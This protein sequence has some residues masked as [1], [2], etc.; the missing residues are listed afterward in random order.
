MFQDMLFTWS[1]RCASILAERV[2]DMLTFIQ[3]EQSNILIGKKQMT[4][5]EEQ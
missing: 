1:F 5:P 3:A 4:V 2:Q